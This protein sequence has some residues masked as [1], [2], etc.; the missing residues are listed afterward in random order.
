[1]VL[2]AQVAAFLHVALTRHEVCS[3]GELIEASSEA[4]APVEMLSPTAGISSDSEASAALIQAHA[5]CMISAQLR[6]PT[7]VAE[8]GLVP[9]IVVEAPTLSSASRH[10][11]HGR[12]ALDRAPKQSPPV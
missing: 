8:L 11:G 4:P 3:H 9:F 6:T 7:L 10:T 2:A 5:H 1:L 12:A